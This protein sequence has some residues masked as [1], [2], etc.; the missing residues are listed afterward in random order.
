MHHL[1]AII[2]DDDRNRR[3]DVLGVLPE[4]VDAVEVSSAE[5]ALDYLKRDVEGILPDFVVLNAD[6]PKNFGLYVFDWMVNRSGDTGIASIPVIVLTEDEFSDRSLEFLEIG[7]VVFYEGSIEEGDL[8]STINSAIEQAEFM[9][10]PVIPPYEE[11]K[12]VDRLMGHTVKA[13]DDRQRAV[14]LDMETR[15]SNLE[16]ALARGRQRAE[17]IR[18]VLEAA[19][20]AKEDDYFDWPVRTRHKRQETKPE[21]KINPI[22]RL[23]EK[24]ISNPEGAMGAQGMPRMEER[25]KS[26]ADRGFSQAKKTIV[27]AD[28]D[29]KTRKLCA[30]FLT[31]KYN[32]VVFDS[33]M[34]T[35]DFF[36][37]NSADLLII[38]PV[39]GEMSGISAVSSIQMQAGGVDVPV[40]YIVGED[41]DEPRNALLGNNVF[42][43]LN[44]P[45]KQGLLSQAVDGFFDN[46]RPGV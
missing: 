26:N 17:D 30:L 15:E 28:G 35:I 41:Y 6:D 21:E 16:A 2:I 25:P 34:K 1:R 4:Y 20:K 11:T 44:K 19:K 8:F 10:E 39:F 46:D 31:Q 5:G 37:K 29:L 12:A 42:G 9:P 22:D 24:A 32:V 27:I 40:M 38:N 3:E 13:P 23:K 45:I 7:D 33:A 18:A 14:L 36:I 43:I